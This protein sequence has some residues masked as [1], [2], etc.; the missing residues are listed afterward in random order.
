MGKKNT[1]LLI[2]DDA[3]VSDVYQTKLSHEGFEIS[4]AEN[5]IKA[6]ERLE[7]ITPDIILLDIVMPYMDGKEVLK[8]LK[9]DKKWENIPVII[10]TNL[11]QK[12]EVEELLEKG[13]DDYLIKSHFTPSEVVGKIK[14]LLK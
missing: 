3:F 7:K 2:E 11:S 10:L 1:I 9:K 14:S 13:A 12:E 4:M 8:R 6:M 5:G